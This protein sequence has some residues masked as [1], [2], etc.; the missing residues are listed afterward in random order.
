MKRQQEIKFFKTSFFLFSPHPSETPSLP[1]GKEAL[2]APARTGAAQ[3]YLTPNSAKTIQQNDC[4]P[5]KLPS[6][7]RF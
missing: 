7:T 3:I 6:W 1:L 4:I 5:K 2:A